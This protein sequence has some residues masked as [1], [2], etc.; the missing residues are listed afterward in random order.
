MLAM[1]GLA[2][3]ILN[4]WVAMAA[5]LNLSLPSGGPVATLWGLVI[6]AIGNISMAA[7]L[8]EICHVFPSSGGPYHWSAILSPPRYANVISWCCGWFAWA[9]WTAL[10]ATTGS[11]AGG[12]LTGMYAL[13]H[14]DYEVKDWQIFVIYLGYI[15]IATI[16]NLYGSRLLPLVNSAAIIW[17]L[18]GALVIIITCLACASPNYQTGTFVFGTYLNQSGW[19]N[20]VAYIL[21]LLQS[22]FGLIGIDALSHMVEEVPQPHINIPNAM[23]LAVTIGASSS[24]IVLV[25]LLFV[26]K[27]YDG[28]VS[29]AAGPLLEI[30]Y[31]AT[32]NVA[33]AICL[34]V[35]PLVA[36]EFAAQGILCACSRMTHAFARDHGELSFHLTWRTEEKTANT[37]AFPPGLPF[38]KFFSKLNPRTGVPDRAVILTSV[39]VIIFG[40]IYLGS[41]SALNAIFRSSVF[42]N[43]S[44][45]I[46]IALLLFR[47]RH[48][49]RPESF[50]EPTWTL[51]PILGPV[52]NSIALAFT[53]FTTVFFL[54]PPDLPVTPSN[55]N[56]AVAVFGVV[57]IFSALTWFVQGRQT[58]TGPR[59]LGGLFELARA[60]VD[61]GEIHPK[62]SNSRSNSHHRG[63]GRDEA[64]T[65]A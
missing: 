37:P 6:S 25:C 65:E 10:V 32:G 8:A 27:D 26:M 12:L 19:N 52:A 62:S 30:L 29:S 51:G 17:S 44:Y 38:S 33:G 64:K 55:M 5:S 39:L 42:L 16:I 24:F 60:E 4:S 50:P 43:V 46:P 54:F 63:H 2:Y 21:G 34:Q 20:G 48:L 22:S 28:V 59:D 45:C 40:L 18:V 61:R 23:L 31:Q 41:S 49:L 9:G 3:A 57:F 35:F 1:V 58:F 36:M 15:I 53:V 14:P 11:L 7:S 56:Y 47:G 13:A